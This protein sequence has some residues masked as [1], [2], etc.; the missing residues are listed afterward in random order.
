MAMLETM[1]Q[2]MQQT[3]WGL[4]L[5]ASLGLSFQACGGSAVDEVGEVDRDAGPDCTGSYSGTYDGDVLGTLEGTL[6]STR[7]FSVTFSPNNSDTSYTISG[8]IGEDGS[9]DISQG[10]SL[11]GTFNFNRCRASGR[12]NTGEAAGTWTATL[13]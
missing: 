2:T 8:S 4:A 3:R 13:D 5:A 9:I 12:W 11:T 6:T 7:S 10:G 1:R